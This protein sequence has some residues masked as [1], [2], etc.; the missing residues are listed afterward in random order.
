MR[1]LLT[2]GA[3]FIGSHLAERLLAE[4]H[5]VDVLD[6]FSTGSPANLRPA[7]AQGGGRLSVTEGTILDAPLVGRLAGAADLV[8]HLAAAVGV[9]R[10]MEAPSAS[11]L[12]NVR[13][14]ETVLAA[15]LPG[16]TPVMIASTSEVYGKAGKFPFAEGDDLVIGATANLRW[17]YAA[18]KLV[19][20]FLALA[21]HREHGLPVTVLRFF[22]TTGP[23]QTGRYGMVLPTFV[24]AALAGAPL[25]VHGDGTQSRC[26][27]HV[28]D[29]VEA[30]MR[31]IGNAAAP[32]GV[33]N[34]GTDREVTILGLAGTV[35]AMTGSASEIRLVPYAEAY[36]PGFEDMM[37]RVPDV[38]RLAAAT[39][40]RPGTPLET[41]IADVIAEKRAAAAA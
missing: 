40:F 25:L 6:D 22:N 30:V 23:R 2:G 12:T 26:F 10:I 24:A 9:R 21:L 34:I 11:I 33:F 29:V 36:G 8:I 35:K 38:S 17:S 19:D 15:C 31:L 7:R 37:R 41:I 32:G 5:R 27:C 14:T 39:G 3:G 28:R 13:G 1:V 18:A 20:E 4:G 16:R